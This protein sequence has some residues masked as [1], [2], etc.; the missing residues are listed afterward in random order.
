MQADGGQQGFKAWKHRLTS[1]GP[2][3]GQEWGSSFHRKREGPSGAHKDRSRPSGKDMQA[4]LLPDGHPVGPRR[5]GAAHE[6]R[7]K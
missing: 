5:R 4:R 7:R 2:E 3:P 1:K 6:R